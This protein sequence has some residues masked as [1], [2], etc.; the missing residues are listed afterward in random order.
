MSERYWRDL[1]DWALAHVEPDGSLVDHGRPVQLDA[2]DRVMPGRSLSGCTTP[3]AIPMGGPQ[4]RGPA[5]G[6]APGVAAAGRR[7]SGAF[8]HTT[9]EPGQ[10]WSDGAYMSTA[11]LL[12]LRRPPS[13]IVKPSTRTRALDEAANQL[14]RYAQVLVVRSPACR[15][16]GST[17]GATPLGRT[18]RPLA[19]DLVPLGRLVRHEPRRRAGGP[20]RPA[21][22][23]PGAPAWPSSSPPCNGW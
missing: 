4:G 7:P 1:D 5:A 21:P 8:V 13:A 14:G 12:A 18:G 19:L 22:P 9:G 6:P 16:M 11:F 2:L 3:A 20:G 23:I 10:I 15:S 17:P